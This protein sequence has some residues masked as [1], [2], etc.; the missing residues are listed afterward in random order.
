[1]N[2][3]K[4]DRVNC[5][6]VLINISIHDY[7][8]LINKA[9]VERGGIEGQRDALKSSTAIRIRERL[10]K[11][12]TIGAVIPPVVVGVIVEPEKIE[13]IENISEQEFR[14]LVSQIVPDNVS[15]IDGM[16]RTT[17]L[18]KAI[19]D[20]ASSDR[21]I[22]VEFWIS[23]DTKSLIY[24]M[25][26]LNSGQVPWDLR[27]QIEVVFS[28]MVHE[29]S[30]KVPNIELLKLD[31]QRRRG[32]AG[33]Q[34]QADRIIELFLVFGARKEKVDTKE[35]LADEFTRLDL[36]E[37]TG[38]EEFVSIFY[39]A[40]DLLG[41]LDKQFSR[42]RPESDGRNRFNIGKDLFS[43]QPACIGFILAIARY[44]LGRP[45]LDLEPQE[46]KRR[47]EALVS[48]ANKLIERLNKLNDNDEIG[49]FLDFV[50]LNE[51]ISR[52]T[53]KVGEFERDFFHKAFGA[54]IEDNFS[55]PNMTPCW[56]AY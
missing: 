21:N 23:L 8:G 2:V 55:F 12:L 44:V 41:R 31:D 32:S 52:R 43:S 38:N 16:Q 37:A 47:W 46:Q 14:E 11:D 54:L 6:S 48:E 24:R 13:Q 36:I 49:A 28:S 1:M 19:E 29:M 15:I 9:Y 25:L 10:I 18:I 30:T 51:A 45:G 5:I 27:R 3:L 40:I 7:L 33:G 17:A 50:T 56:R 34:F 39:Q 22:R 35:R 53:G 26:V 42:Y 20:G 4:D